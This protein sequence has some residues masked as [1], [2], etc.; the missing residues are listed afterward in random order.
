[1]Q[2]LA[3][4]QHSFA[5][6]NRVFHFAFEHDQV[7]RLVAQQIVH[8]NPA[9]IAEHWIAGARAANGFVR[10]THRGHLI[11]G[12]VAHSLQLS[13][14]VTV[15]NAQDAGPDFPLR[16][17]GNGGSQHRARGRQEIPSIRVHHRLPISESG[18]RTNR[19]RLRC[20]V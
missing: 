17:S 13:S 12:V 6:R 19:M 15:L 5:E 11:I 7:D 10:F 20:H 3:G 8:R 14:Q 18:T 4:V 1:M 9:Q 16:C 2:M